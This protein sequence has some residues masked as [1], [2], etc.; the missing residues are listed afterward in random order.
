MNDTFTRVDNSGG[1]VHAGQGDVYNIT[2]TTSHFNHQQTAGRSPRRI[3]D[4]QLR[5]LRQRFVDPEGMG[6]ARRLLAEHSTVILDGPPGSG[7]TAA[8]RVL[9][10][11]LHQSTGIF[12]ELLPGDH[13]EVALTDTGLVGAGDRLLLDLAEADVQRWARTHRD[14]SALRKAVQ[15]QQAHLVVVMPHDGTLESDL[16]LYRAKISHPPAQEVFRRH[17]RLH[18]V[19]HEEYLQPAP[20]FADFLD[21]RRSMEEIADFADRVRRARTAHRPPD[22]FAGWCEQARD[23]RKTWRQEVAGL[24]AERREAP[25]RALLFTT[26]MLHGAHADVIHHATALLLRTL[27]TPRDNAHLL[28]GKD[29]SERLTEITASA[30]PDG[31]VRFDKL[32]FDTA[33]R[34]HFWDHMPDLRPLLSAWTDRTAE[35][36]DR[37]LTA[38]RRRELVQRLADQYLRTGKWR[39]LAALA[40]VWGTTTT[41]PAR[42]AAAIHVLSR[43]LESKQYGGNFRELIYT[44]C[45]DKQLAGDLADV[46]LRVCTDVIAPTYPDQAMVRL[47]HLARRERG[48]TPALDALCDL[49][50]TSSRLRRRMLDRLTRHSSAPGADAGLFLRICD[51]VPLTDP[52]GSPRA[53]MDENY[54]QGCVTT[55]WREVFAQLPQPRWQPYARRWLHTASDAGDRRDL[56]LDLLVDAADRDGTHLAALYSVAR[57]AEPTTSGG[58][59][60]GVDTTDRLLQKISA[61][62]GLRPPATPPRP[63]PPRG[64][65][66]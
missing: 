62:Q 49:V 39:E 7:R 64:T 17:L 36:A 11:E 42:P 21:D 37:H 46:L 61:A 19:P 53:L 3:A 35:L 22:D 2:Y 34:V 52:G 6:E 5:L 15:E 23:A 63:E 10:Y 38:D 43:G 66:P 26:A 44:W 33:V 50:A 1:S 58:A 41:N 13:E 59:A 54:V 18:H 48:A 9:L 12:R 25:Q 27:K 29:L 14:L 57:A 30:G 20:A 16:Q 65:T 45:R 55:G 56:L 51:P 28:E 24:V 31:H 60:R 40:D 32:G 4:D 8:A 47:H